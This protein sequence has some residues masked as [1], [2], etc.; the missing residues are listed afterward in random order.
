LF[1]S[2]ASAV[3]AEPSPTVEKRASCTPASGASDDVP[4]IML[5]I[6]ACPS[7]TIVIPQGKTYNIGSQ[8]LFTGCAG[9]T[10]QLDGTLKVTTDFTYWNGK[11]TIIYVKNID[12]ITVTSPAKTGIIDGQGQASW[13]HIVSNSAYSRPNL[14][15]VDGSKNVKITWVTFKNSPKF[16]LVTAGSSTN[17]YYS[18]L[19]VYAVSTSSNG[20]KNTDAFDVGPASWVT[21]ERLTISNSDDCVVLKPGADHVEARDIHCTGSH[22]L[23]VGSLASSSGSTDAVTNSL[24][25][26]AV[27][28]GSTKALGIKIY[29]AGPDHGSA[30]V[31]NVTWKDVKCDGC[32]YALQVESCYGEDDDYCAAYPSTGQ[33]SGVTWQ[34]ITGTTSGKY[35]SNI[36]NI[37]CPAAGSCGLTIKG[38]SAKA[39]NGGSTVLCANTPSSLGVTCTPGASG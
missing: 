38:L 36:A 18:D 8:L 16:H 5:A 28:T 29:P 11:G 9:C 4:A 30:L 25:E 3:L 10:L 39:K 31:Q 7:G 21:L 34:N 26:R 13:D 19:T 24:F 33:I 6:A 37:N 32:E 2:F 23:S 22:G 14:M 15:R 1:F 12:G 27:M 17:V 35:G 20:A